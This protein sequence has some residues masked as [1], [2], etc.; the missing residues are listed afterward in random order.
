MIARSDV[1]DA[2]FAAAIAAEAGRRLVALRR[3]FA[4][5]H[6]LD[7]RRRGRALGDAG[8]ASSERYLAEQFALA[9]P[10]DAVLSEEADDGA[11]RDNADRVWIVDPLDGTWEFGQGRDDWAVHVALWQ[12]DL[13][14]LSVGV[15]ALP[16]DDLVLRADAPPSLPDL[17]LERPLRVVASRSRPP[18]WL[19]TFTG[20]LAGAWAGLG[21][22][23]A[24]EI[25]NVGSVGAKVARIL[26]GE[27]DVY[28]HDS[29][30]FE[31]DAAAP[32]A[33]ARA[34]GLHVAHLDGAPLQ[35]ND[36]PPRVADF[37]VCRPELAD[38]VQHALDGVV[39]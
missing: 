8:D 7:P 38:A 37:C 23:A 1:S 21:G 5:P 17:A 18:S 19:R 16:D 6:K 12:R 27:V 4:T 2:D 35:F 29:G 24:A 13:G 9:R 32:Y 11:A 33:V 28:V 31:W 3:D 34:A 14:G 20:Q 15:V 26:R 36:R 25:V 30:F 10:E 39:T 22:P